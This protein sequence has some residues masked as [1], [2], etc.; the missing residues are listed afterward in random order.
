[1]VSFG[2]LPEPVSLLQSKNQEGIEGIASFILEKVV[3]PRRPL[4]AGQ[5]AGFDA[6]TAAS[7]SRIRRID[8]RGH[9]RVRVIE[10]GHVECLRTRRLQNESDSR[11]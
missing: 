8:L 1:M 7:C 4:I 10:V 11:S 2:H 3:W 6:L 9:P 5:N